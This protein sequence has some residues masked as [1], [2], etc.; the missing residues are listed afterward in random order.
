MRRPSRSLRT[1]VHTYVRSYVVV[2]VVVVVAVVAVVCSTGLAGVDSGDPRGWICMYAAQ[3]EFPF[4]SCSSRKA[5]PR[6]SRITRVIRRKRWD[7]VPSWPTN[8]CSLRVTLPLIRTYIRVLGAG[9]RRTCRTYVSLRTMR[10][11]R[12]VHPGDGFY[13][14]GV[15]REGGG[16]EVRPQ[17]VLRGTQGSVARSDTET[18]KRIH[19]QCRSRLMM[20]TCTVPIYVR[21]R[22]RQGGYVRTYGS[23]CD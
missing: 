6:A 10:R 8:V 4:I 18:Y 20:C 21:A 11:I 5:K 12:S 13:N 19:E 16:F 23:S 15:G 2:D 7:C 22:C 14:G 9:C 3:H 1:L 17:V